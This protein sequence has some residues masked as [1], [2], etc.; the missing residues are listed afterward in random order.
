M[1]WPCQQLCPGHRLAHVLL[2]WGVL[3]LCSSFKGLT[4]GPVVGAWPFGCVWVDVS[5]AESLMSFQ[6]KILLAGRTISF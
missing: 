2:G 3:V 6:S 4:P 5:R 1:T